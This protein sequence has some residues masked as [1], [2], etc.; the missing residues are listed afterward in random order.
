LLTSFCAVCQPTATGTLQAVVKDSQGAAIPG[1]QIT[2]R[3]L[4]RAVPDARNQ[5]VPAPGETV[6]SGAASADASGAFAL[7]SLPAGYAICAS[8]PGLPYLDPCKWSAGPIVIVSAN[9]TTGYTL[10]LTKGV[11]LNVRINDPTHQLPQVKDEPL[12]AGKLIVGVKF[13]DGAYQGAPNTGVDAEGRD[14]QMVV[15]AGMPLQLWLFSRDVALTDAGGKPVNSAG[16]TVPF[17]AVAGQ[18][19]NFTFVVSGPLA[20]TF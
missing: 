10:A 4:F 1:A 6:K 8:V 7:L 15:P 14:Y 12:R 2:Y 11:F 16:A 17:Q 13:G 19:Q 18:D 20:R 5:P 9:A 3:R